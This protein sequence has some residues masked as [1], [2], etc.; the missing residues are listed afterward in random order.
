MKTLPQIKAFYFTPIPRSNLQITGK[1]YR[2]D[3]PDNT[4]IYC[5]HG[6]WTWEE[7][8]IYGALPTLKPWD[9]K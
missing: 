5:Y 9:E 7:L 1:K 8:H 4:D 3:L 6:Y 2:Q